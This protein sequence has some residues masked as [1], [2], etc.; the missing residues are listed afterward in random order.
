LSETLN[1]P[2]TAPKAVGVNVMLTL[3]LLP[4]EPNVAP[5]L[6]AEIANGGLTAKLVKSRTT[7]PV[8]VFL[9]VTDFA[10]EVVSTA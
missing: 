2:F 4:P 3:Q 8:A 7:S 9:I 10:A 5:Q 1:A 6:L